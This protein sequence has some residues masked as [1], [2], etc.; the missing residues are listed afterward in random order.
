MSF[1][2]TAHIGPPT[3]KLDLNLNNARYMQRVSN[4][5][6]DGHLKNGIAQL[7]L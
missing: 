7:N 6:E 1:P 4:F 5:L 2:H 3:F